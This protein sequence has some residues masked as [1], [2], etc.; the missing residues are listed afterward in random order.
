MKNK[1]F[2]DFMNTF[3]G[4][5]AGFLCPII[6]VAIISFP[7]FIECN[8][9]MIQSLYTTP[10]LVAGFL[11]ISVLMPLFIKKP[12]NTILFCGM[13]VFAIIIAH[14]IRTVLDVEFNQ[15]II[16]DEFDISYLIFPM[17][18]AAGLK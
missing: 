15:A 4:V 7:K 11:I 10:V 16:S 1:S 13:L 17:P 9:M 12:Q 3:A 18:I 8:P 5:V 14:W 2:A 6:P